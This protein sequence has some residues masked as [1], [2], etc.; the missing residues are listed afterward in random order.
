MTVDFVNDETKVAEVRP[1]DGEN[2]ADG[3]SALIYDDLKNTNSQGGVGQD[4]LNLFIL[5]ISK[6]CGFSLKLPK[7]K[8]I[9]V[10][11]VCDEWVDIDFSEEM[12]RDELRAP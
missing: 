9:S 12:S 3:A 7:T 1:Q 6:S 10:S 2:G 8:K 11:D 5:F 4:E